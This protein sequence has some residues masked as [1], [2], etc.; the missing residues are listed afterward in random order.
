MYAGEEYQAVVDAVLAVTDRIGG[1][2]SR[3]EVELMR[4]HFHATAR[5]EWMFWDAAYR[6]EDWP[7]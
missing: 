6:S 1:Q 7:V 4:R 5:Y 3:R 2:A